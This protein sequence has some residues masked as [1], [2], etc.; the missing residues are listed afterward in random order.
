MSQAILRFW[1]DERGM[2]FVLVGIS[3]MAF[4]AATS[5]AVDVG[6]LLTARTQAQ[7]AADSGALAGATAIAFNNYNDRSTTG[8]AVQ[9]AV[10]AAQANVIMGASA[11]GIAKTVGPPDVTF[12]NSPGGLPNRVQVNVHRTSAAGNPLPT[13]FARL[14]G[15]PW[16]SISAS[17][18]AEASP[19]DA[20]T[21]VKP[22]MIPDKWI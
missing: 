15:V 18:T 17:A 11:D 12:P 4:V 21:C 13:F 10:H 5:L 1:R 16:V 9:S 14:F 3:L 8:P 6:M 2:S 22:F 19:A 20:M 7:T